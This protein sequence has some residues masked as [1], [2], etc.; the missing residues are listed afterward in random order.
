MVGHQD[1]KPPFWPPPPGWQSRET[2]GSETVSK[3]TPPYWPPPAGWQPGVDDH[4]ATDRRRGRVELFVIG[5]VGT[6]ALLGGS[7]LTLLGVVVL[8]VGRHQAGD[9]AV[10]AGFTGLI[11][12]IP[13]LV[14]GVIAWRD[15]WHRQRDARPG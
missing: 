7:G 2:P 9:G 15:L 1:D 12:G 10:I 6:L 8:I 13:L 5:T 3:D 14:G 4:V 11:F